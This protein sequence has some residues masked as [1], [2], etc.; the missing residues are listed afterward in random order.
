MTL[1]DKVR[2]EM[3]GQQKLGISHHPELLAREHVL[4]QTAHGA[5]QSELDKYADY[6][7]VYRAYTWVRKAVGVIKDSVASLPLN[8]VNKEG[9]PIDGHPLKELYE[10]VNDEHSPND[11]WEEYV[12]NLMLGGEVFFEFVPSQSGNKI[13]EIW[14]RRPDHVGVRPDETEERLLY[15]RVAGYSFGD[16][17]NMILPEFMYHD[18]FFNPLNPWRGIGPITAVRSAIVIDLFASAW[19][20]AFLKHG[21]RPDYA[22]ITPEGTTRTE[23]EEIETELM[24]RY[25]GPAN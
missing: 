4:V 20:K 23:K 13:V 25:A 22:I 6:A 2:A 19:S 12:V 15:P 9:K 8:V 17:D 7:K 16:D 1:L 18:K 11:L 10:Y 24:E 21:A 5:M 3:G 14:S